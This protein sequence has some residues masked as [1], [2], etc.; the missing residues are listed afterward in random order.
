M[1][2]REIT[3]PE[4]VVDPRAP[5]VI[6]PPLRG[7]GWVNANGCCLAD[8]PH[9]ATRLVVDGSQYVK[10]ETFAIDWVRLEG[11][12]QWTG[13][14]AQNEQHF[15]FGADVVAV[16]EG[17]VVAVRDDMPEE[18][19]RQPPVAVQHAADYAGNHVVVQ[20]QPEVW[21]IYAHLQPGSISVGVGE[22]VTTGQRLG[23]LGNSGNTTDPHLHFQISDGP[24]ALSSNS[25][26]FVFDR[27]T[28]A[29][30]VAPE[31]MVAAYTDPSAPREVPIEGPPH[32]QSGTHPLVLTVQD[33]R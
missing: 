1:D 16:A 20:M 6:A 22:R 23:G 28:L 3:I 25:L 27:Y 29:G 2:S 30:T 7:A 24:D 5:L 32:A 21:A 12:R 15:A 13:D 9:R 18:T 33:F 31:A 10:P 8:T 19:P 17:T 14:G 4:L 26:P 11:G